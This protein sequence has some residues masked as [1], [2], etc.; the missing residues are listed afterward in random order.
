[1]DDY[2]GKQERAFEEIFDKKC[3]FKQK[4]NKIISQIRNMLSQQ[5][6][7]G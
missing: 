3:K 5:K 7:R 1:M 2:Y 4:L 6:Q